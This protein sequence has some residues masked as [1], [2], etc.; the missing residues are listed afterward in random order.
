MKKNQVKLGEV[1]SAKVTGRIA[2]V[3]IDRANPRGGWD[4]TNVKTQKAVR[5]R[6]AQRLRGKAATWPGKPQARASGDGVAETVAAVEK[7]NLAEGIVVP[8]PKR[9]R[10]GISD[11]ATKAAAVSAAMEAVQAGKRL[12]RRER[13]SGLDAAAMVLAESKGKLGAGEI[14]ERAL[15]RGLW[16]SKGKTPAA[17]IYAAMIREIA[18]KGTASRFRKV[19]PNE[20]Q[21]TR[22]G[23]QAAAA[24]RGHK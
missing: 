1:Y 9:K 2:P 22:A 10:G 15:A 20:F 18:A 11:D 24:V 4:G 7:G 8:A 23:R 16:Q 17:T 6:S 14:V 13:R 21:L 12:D 5:I 3:R 19:G